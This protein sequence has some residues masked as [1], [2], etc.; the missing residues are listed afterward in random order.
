MTIHYVRG[1]SDPTYLTIDPIV[2]RGLVAAHVPVGRCDC[3]GYA[4]GETITRPSRRGVPFANAT[5]D[6]CGAEA[7]YPV[8]E[9]QPVAA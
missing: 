7:T 9:P 6:R 2:W 8:R 5:C 3:G 1:V 4:Y